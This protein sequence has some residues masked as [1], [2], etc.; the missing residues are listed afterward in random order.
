LRSASFLT[1]GELLGGLLITILDSGW[2]GAQ[3]VLQTD[4][5]VTTTDKFTT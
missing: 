1:T 3:V 5:T 2:A 4:R